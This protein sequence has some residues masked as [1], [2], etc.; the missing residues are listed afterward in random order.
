MAAESI[1]EIYRT[2]EDV[3]RHYFVAAVTITWF[4]KK[5]FIQGLSGT[6]SLQCWRE[7]KD[8]LMS[9]GCIQAQYYRKGVLK[10]VNRP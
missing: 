4:G 9:K 10:I 3:S 7:L 1:V 8:Y 5:A 6:F 2:Q